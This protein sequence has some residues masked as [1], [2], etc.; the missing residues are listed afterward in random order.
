MNWQ[1]VVVKNI[2]KDIENEDFKR[3]YLIYGEEKYLVRNIKNKLIKA[4]V[5]DGDNMNFSKFSGKDCD[6]TKTIDL[7]ETLP[8]FA[9]YR[10]VLLEIG[11]AHV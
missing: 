3:V 7:A 9:K 1:V 5:N 10:V 8:F 6:V 4:I 2:S 11:R